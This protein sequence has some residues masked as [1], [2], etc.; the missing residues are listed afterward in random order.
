M[1]NRSFTSTDLRN[2]HT[3]IQ[4]ASIK[5]H[6]FPSVILCYFWL[7]QDHG[8]KKLWAEQ[9]FRLFIILTMVISRRKKQWYI[10]SVT[11]GAKYL[12][13]M[14]T[15]APLYKTFSLIKNN[16]CSA[17]SYLNPRSRFNATCLVENNVFYSLCFD[18]TG[19]RTHDFC[20]SFYW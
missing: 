13:G 14:V 16:V 6:N 17:H 11:F 4:D 20:L 18:P 7:N 8:Y 1:M 3:C 2:I 10:V 15:S 12:T 19:A 9:T 5:M